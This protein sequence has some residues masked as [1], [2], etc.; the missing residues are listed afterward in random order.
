MEKQA[1]TEI[2][3]EFHQLMQIST[4]L[5]ST[6]NRLSMRNISKE[7]LRRLR[8]SG[9]IRSDLPAPQQNLPLHLH[10]FSHRRAAAC[11]AAAASAEAHYYIYGLADTL[12]KLS[13][14]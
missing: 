1:I 11:F 12:S 6:A 9:T 4:A 13:V 8:E 7:S 10:L 14:E 3:D 5:E 2:K